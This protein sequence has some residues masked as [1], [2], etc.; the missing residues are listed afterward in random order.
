MD[1]LNQ[2]QV[3]VNV[4]N[5]LVCQVGMSKIY[6]LMNIEVMNAD[7]FISLQLE[8][9]PRIAA[10]KSIVST[11]DKY[12]NEMKI[13]I[14][15]KTAMLDFSVLA[16]CACFRINGVLCNAWLGLKDL[17]LLAYFDVKSNLNKYSDFVRTKVIEQLVSRAPE[18]ELSPLH[19]HLLSKLTLLALPVHAP[20][21]KCSRALSEV[22][23][24]HMRV[25]EGHA[26]CGVQCL[27]RHDFHRNE[28]NHSYSFRV[29]A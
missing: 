18:E 10:K 17:S 29:R 13:C 22:L 23:P 5:R 15:E 16:K 27:D 7:S 12:G 11:F 1:A 14:T 8:E 24:V 2:S 20:C 6:D 19:R 3:L 28:Y 26:F 25:C 9:D 4:F 21:K